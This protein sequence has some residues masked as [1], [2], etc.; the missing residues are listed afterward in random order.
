MQAVTY[1][2]IVQ[3][4]LRDTPLA[5]NVTVSPFKWNV[6]QPVGT[7][8]YVRLRVIMPESQSKPGLPAYLRFALT[9][10]SYR[11]LAFATNASIGTA[12][13]ANNLQVVGATSASGAVAKMSTR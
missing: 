4:R 10:T 6:T 11:S 7:Y 8:W 3:D 13:S 5:A 12:I 2:F 1:S 9:G